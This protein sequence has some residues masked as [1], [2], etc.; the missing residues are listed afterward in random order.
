MFHCDMIS[1]P[2]IFLSGKQQLLQLLQLW[3]MLLSDLPSC[4]VD[5]LISAQTGAKGVPPIPNVRMILGAYRFP[6]KTSAFVYGYMVHTLKQSEK[7]TL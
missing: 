3:E 2:T 1:K 5:G 4:Q 7:Q 6:A